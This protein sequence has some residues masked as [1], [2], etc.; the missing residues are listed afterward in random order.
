MKMNE[1]ADLIKVE[2]GNVARADALILHQA[3]LVCNRGWSVTIG[4]VVPAVDSLWA[5]SC[6][7]EKA[8]WK[9]DVCTGLKNCHD[10]VD[11][12]IEQHIE[13]L[14]SLLWAT[15]QARVAKE[16]ILIEQSRL[17]Y[18]VVQE[19]QEQRGGC[20]GFP[21]IREEVPPLACHYRQQPKQ[22]PFLIFW[23]EGPI[24]MARG[25]CTERS[26]CSGKWAKW[27]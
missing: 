17:D 27:A 7:T 18:S 6:H 16:V 14:G 8:V 21:R 13:L 1:D 3:A 11:F 9:I 15:Q 24:D 4:H 12:D 23:D 26:W 20:Q 22:H 19:A 10:C 5:T 25:Q 2:P